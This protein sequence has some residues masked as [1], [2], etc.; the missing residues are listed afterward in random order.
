MCCSE[1]KSG[2]QCPTE[3]KGKP[4]ECAPQ[5]IEKCHGKTTQHACVPE[6]PKKK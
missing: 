2:C 3:L 4:E 5:Q 6:E 1:N